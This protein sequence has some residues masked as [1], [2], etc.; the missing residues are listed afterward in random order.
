VINYFPEREEKKIMKTFLI[1]SFFCCLM[2]TS[3]FTQDSTSQRRW[4]IDPESGDTVYSEAVIVSQSQDITPRHS[5][6]IINPLK[7]LLFYNISYYHKISDGFAVGFGL[8]T[9]TLSGISGFGV[10][11]ETRLYPSGRNLKGFYFAPNVS[12]N[13]LSTSGS[14]ES[15]SAGSVGVLIGWQWFPGDEF[16]IGLGLGMD[17][18]FLS[19]EETDLSQYNGT[20][21]LLRFDIGYAW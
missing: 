18:Y 16:A 10:N 2:F 14:N 4:T 13:R 17:Y 21:P 3:A 1:S 19:N 12:Y 9:P 11:A 5:M 7:F 20:A 8:Q 15:V 6:L